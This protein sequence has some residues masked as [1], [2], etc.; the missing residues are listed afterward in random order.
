M[1]ILKQLSTLNNV[2]FQTLKSQT[3]NE[4][5]ELL[6]M[7]RWN[8]ENEIS[9]RHKFPEHLGSVQEVKGT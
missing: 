4:D 2:N 8:V 1:S 9:T 3:R 6:A 5:D 7:V